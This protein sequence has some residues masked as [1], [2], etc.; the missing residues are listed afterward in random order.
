MGTE[1]ERN[2]EG[3]EE[4]VPEITGSATTQFGN[5]PQPTTEV[6]REA[7]LEGR[8]KRLNELKGKAALE[9]LLEMP[10]KGPR[11]S[12]IRDIIIDFFGVED[13]ELTNG[14]MM[15]LRQVESAI[16]QGNTGAYNAIK[17]RVLGAPNQKMEIE[18]STD[19]LQLLMKT[20]KRR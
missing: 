15:D 3:T 13:A 11:D 16:K 10:Y 14:V 1:N 6:R 2:Q 4:Q 9:L 7:Q 8:R 18:P 19:F 17:N 20:S 5:R 12:K